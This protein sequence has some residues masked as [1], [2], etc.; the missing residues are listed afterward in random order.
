MNKYEK[1]LKLIYKKYNLKLDS[2]NTINKN[3]LFNEYFIKNTEDKTKL[4]LLS[5]SLKKLLEDINYKDI[6]DLVEYIIS[7]IRNIKGIKSSEYNICKEIKN[8]EKEIAELEFVI[9]MLENCS[10]DIKISNR[11]LEESNN[12]DLKKVASELI[13]YNYYFNKYQYNKFIFCFFKEYKTIIK[14]LADK[15][16]N[17]NSN[18]NYNSFI[19]IIKLINNYSNILKDSNSKLT[20]T[21]KESK[22][23]LYFKIFSSRTQLRS[24]S[25]LK[26]LADIDNE[27]NKKIRNIN[28]STIDFYNKNGVYKN[29]NDLKELSNSIVYNPLY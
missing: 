8:I 19:L 7:T 5:N 18:S 17:E 27:F 15:D 25:N 29:L 3:N 22:S 24:K 6:V 23:N 13:N 2:I 28:K 14:K 21:K 16:T 20:N 4:N 12:I 26:N 9:N 1:Y 11:K 10:S